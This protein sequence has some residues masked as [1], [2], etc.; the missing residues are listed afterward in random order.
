MKVPSVLLLASLGCAVVALLRR[1]LADLLLL[2]VPVLIA[3]LYLLARAWRSAR[4]APPALTGLPVIID[5]SNVMYWADGTPRIEPLHAVLRMLQTQGFAPGV[6]FDANAG[7]LL[8]GRYRHDHALAKLLGLH[9]DHVMVADKGQPADPL[10]LRA[11]RDM[12]AR[13]V[14]NDRFRDWADTYPEVQAPGFLIRGGYRDGQLW[15]DLDPDTIN[16]H[17][18]RPR[19]AR[20]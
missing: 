5:G 15:L 20:C 11:A 6:V 14:T 3:S 4:H 9:T 2:A 18:E 13:V 17:S 1:D 12:Q 7:H 19:I 16:T 8:L 10:I